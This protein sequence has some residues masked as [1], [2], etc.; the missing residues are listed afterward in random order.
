MDWLS[1]GPGGTG[2]LNGN[3]QVCPAGSRGMRTMASCGCSGVGR[4]VASRG[5]TGAA[6]IRVPAEIRVPPGIRVPPDARVP[7]DAW[8][9]TDVWV[10]ADVPLPADS[11]TDPAGADD[12]V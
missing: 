11:A 3:T 9:P 8:V 6:V 10:P 2:R 5:Q 1:P 7:A 4:S 12:P